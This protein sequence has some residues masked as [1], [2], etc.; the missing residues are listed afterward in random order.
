MDILTDIQNI[1]LTSIEV[2]PIAIPLSKPF[3]NHLRVINKIDGIVC[4]MHT[5]A[6]ISGQGLVY[7]LGE[8]DY[9]KVRDSILISHKQLMAYLT[10]KP[11]ISNELKF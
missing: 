9:E 7:G 1:M 11:E 4:L 5:N 2:I 6:G 8:I 10:S 3:S